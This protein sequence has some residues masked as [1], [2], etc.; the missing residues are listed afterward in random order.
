MIAKLYDIEQCSMAVQDLFLW[1]GLALNQDDLNS[2][3]PISNLSFISKTID[4]VVAVRLY[5]DADANNLLPVRQSAYRTRHSTETRSS[6][7]TMT[8]HETS[9]ALVKLVFLSFWT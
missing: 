6:P 7:Y 1:N 5:E 4:R 8:L 2:Y 9:I 3:R